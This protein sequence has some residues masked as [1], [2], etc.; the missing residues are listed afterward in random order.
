MMAYG[1]FMDTNDIIRQIDTEIS[2][3]Q[4]AERY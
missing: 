2:N 1:G 3:L 4:R